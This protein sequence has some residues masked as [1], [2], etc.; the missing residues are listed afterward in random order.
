MPTAPSSSLR[1]DSIEE[2]LDQV[3]DFFTRPAQRGAP[4]PLPVWADR[5]TQRGPIPQPQ[6]GRDTQP[7]VGAGPV[8]HLGDRVRD[9]DDL[10]VGKRSVS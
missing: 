5:M 1:R 10:A 7:L 4:V 6:R 8:V 3:A 2:D 9:H